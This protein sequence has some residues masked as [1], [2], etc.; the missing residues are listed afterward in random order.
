M[1]C[2]RC[3]VSLL[4]CGL[5]LSASAAPGQSVF[6]VRLD[7]VEATSPTI[8]RTSAV[9]VQTDTHYVQRVAF[10]NPPFSQPLV[11]VSN[12]ADGTVVTAR[13][14]AFSAPSAGG[15]PAFEEGSW[16]LVYDADGPGFWTLYKLIAREGDGFLGFSASGDETN[17]DYR[18]QVPPAHDRV[19]VWLEIFANLPVTFT[20]LF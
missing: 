15:E 13:L 14:S 3:L 8:Q 17:F 18:I 12:P 19:T 11:R 2:I 10:A 20:E 4:C 9:K 16:T 7:D 5:G 1:K 6:P